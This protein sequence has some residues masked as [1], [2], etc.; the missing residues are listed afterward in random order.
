MTAKYSLTS[1]TVSLSFS[2]KSSS[3]QH[4]WLLHLIETQAHFNCSISGRQFICW[5]ISLRTIFRL[6]MFNKNSAPFSPK[7]LRALR[8]VTS[9]SP[10]WE[11]CKPNQ[12]E[13]QLPCRD[14]LMRADRTLEFCCYRE[15]KK[16][17]TASW[18]I[19]ALIAACA[20]VWRSH[21]K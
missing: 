6:D 12:V 21:Y 20:F 8:K 4:N 3:K 10:S 11:V 14:R 1:I 16:R 5:R 2:H 18:E 9:F 13:L 19:A 17:C 7:V 15:R